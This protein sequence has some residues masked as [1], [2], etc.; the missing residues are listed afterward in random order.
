MRIGSASFASF[1]LLAGCGGTVVETAAENGPAPRP[2]AAEAGRSVQPEAGPD[3]R[4]SLA[5][6]G[7][8]EAD[9]ASTCG[10]SYQCPGPSSA[11]DAKGTLQGRRITVSRAAVEYEHGFTNSTLLS[12]QA[13]WGEGPATLLV[14]LRSDSNGV[15]EAQVRPG[16]YGS[17]SADTS[18]DARALVAFVTVATCTGVTDLPGVVVEVTEHS[19][20]ALE[21][22]AVRLR[23][24][25]GISSAPASSLSIPFDIDAVC[26]L[27]DTR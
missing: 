26:A 27:H 11:V 8:R 12:F 24:T 16:V 25:V 18:Q 2:V 9:G 21:G 6:S 23:G 15:P 7:P 22:A 10:A 3:A 13:R 20:N 19:G 1:S 14:T 4:A 5:R 17:P